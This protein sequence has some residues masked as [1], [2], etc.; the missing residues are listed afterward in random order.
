[1][2]CVPAHDFTLSKAMAWRSAIADDPPYQRESSI[3]SLEKQQLF[4]DS[5]LN[6]YDVPKIYLHDLR[7]KHPTRV[8]AV[9][10]GKQRLSAIWGFLTD[11]FPLA[12]DFRV[13]PANLPDLPAGVGH[14]APGQCFSQLDPAWQ[15]ELRRTY[16]AVVLI[17]N[18]TEHDIE[19]LFARLNNGEPLNAAERRNA[20]GGDAVRLIR[21]IAEHAF[22]TARG[23]SAR[24]RYR[25]HDAAA[26]MLILEAAHAEGAGPLPDLRGRAL[27]DFVRAQRRIGRERGRQVAARVESVL[28]RMAD[29]FSAGDPLVA[30][31]QA[32]IGSYLVTRSVDWDRAGDSAG[33]RLNEALRQLH[34]DRRAELDR[35]E[36]EQDPRLRELTELLH[37]GS[38]DAGSLERRRALQLGLLRQRAPE[39]PFLAINEEDSSRPGLVGATGGRL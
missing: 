2:R 23:A 26:R 14:P 28:D 5:L 12:P 7:G 10:D 1:M 21:R 31:Q 25:H 34:A 30:S 8:Y 39:L 15:R 3:W 37:A 20:M 19:D 32:W 4:I 36:A 13:E 24:S 6:G 38:Y 33:A 35:A 22:F 27:D 16:L 9:V 11:A 29:V 18:A 17:R